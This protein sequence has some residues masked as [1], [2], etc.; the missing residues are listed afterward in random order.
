MSDSKLETSLFPS[1]K[2]DA[3]I[4]AH[5]PDAPQTHSPSYRL[6]YADND[7][8]LRDEL[9]ETLTLV[10]T[11]KSNRCRF[12]YLVENSGSRQSTLITSQPKVSSPRKILNYS[13]I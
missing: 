1:A 4:A 2:D 10:Q 3:G 5:P 9:F 12:C 8:L 13:S 6:A 7:F 11:K